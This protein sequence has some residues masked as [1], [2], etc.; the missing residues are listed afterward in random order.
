MGKS[1]RASADATRFLLRPR[2]W[3]RAVAACVLAKTNASSSDAALQP[4]AAPPPAERPDRRS[5]TVR[6]RRHS[7]QHVSVY[8]RDSVE[9]RREMRA[10]GHALPPIAAFAALTARAAR[11]LASPTVLVHT[12][13]L[14]ALADMSAF[15]A[16]TGAFR[17]LSTD[18][19]R[20][21]HDSWG[22]WAAPAAPAPSGTLGPPLPDA[23]A[24][25]HGNSEVGDATL[26]G[27]VN[28]VNLELAS[29]AA[30]L[31]A[32]L[33]SAWTDMMR[34][35]LAAPRGGSKHLAH[36]STSLP[37]RLT[38]ELHFCCGCSR[39]ERIARAGNMIVLIASSLP[40]DEHARVRMALENATIPGCVHYR[41]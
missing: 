19:P 34:V 10:H 11:A 38:S 37:T 32:P 7:T 3:V 15:G 26:H 30:V 25:H 27:A 20:G 28:A 24:R 9:K 22:G 16:A 40:V 4:D 23:P 36:E 13:S 2:P 18:S 17:T 41:Q 6:R 33:F 12:S 31:I 29:R 21:D 1:S 5:S 35:L 39:R 8:I 14:Q